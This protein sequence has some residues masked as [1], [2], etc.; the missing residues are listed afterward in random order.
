MCVFKALL[1]VVTF[2]MGDGVRAIG[3]RVRV[4]HCLVNVRKADGLA[5]FGMKQR[6]REDKYFT[7]GWLYFGSFRSNGKV[8]D[9]GGLPD[10]LLAWFEFIRVVMGSPSTSVSRRWRGPDVIASSSLRA[11]PRWILLYRRF[12]TAL[13]RF[14]RGARYTHSGIVLT[15][16]NISR[17]YHPR[18][19]NK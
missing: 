7:G 17:F 16:R 9:V 15:A 8:R 12:T 11:L 2:V 13:P 18:N 5:P 3:C 1:P 14:L 6:V 19:K 10:T 4:A